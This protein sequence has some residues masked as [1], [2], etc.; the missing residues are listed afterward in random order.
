MSMLYNLHEYYSK[1]EI[2]VGFSS[3]NIAPTF[4]VVL[5]YGKQIPLM[6]FYNRNIY[7]KTMILEVGELE[8]ALIAC[9]VIG[10]RG[11][12]AE[13]IKSCI[14]DKLGIRKESIILA[15]THNHSYP[16]TSDP[17][18]REFIKDK[19]ILSVR[20][21]LNSKFKAKIG[22]GKKKLPVWINVNRTRPDGVVDTTL[23]VI[24]VDEDDAMRG[25]IF[26]FPS[27]PNTHTTAWGG[28][29]PGKIGPEW[30]EYV[31]KYIETYIDREQM[32]NLYPEIDFRD[33]FTMFLLGPA[34]D[35]Q[36]SLSLYR[37]KGKILSRKRVFV[38][39]LGDHIIDLANQIKTLPE[40]SLRFKWAN[41]KIPIRGE[42]IKKIR[43]AS[44]KGKSYYKKLEK[45][46]KSGL[47]ETIIQALIL[48]DSCICTA[49]GEVTADLGL[50]FQRRVKFSH[51]IL[52][53]IAN[54]YLGYFVSEMLG[55]ENIRYEAKGSLLCAERGRILVNSLLS[56]VNPKARLLERVRPDE[57]M[58]I[59][60]G[61]VEYDGDS[62]LYIGIKR[63]CNTPAYGE[64][65]AAPFLGRRIKIEKNGYFRFEKIAPGILYLYVDK[66]I[67]KEKK[68]KLLMWG[69][70]VIVKPKEITKI[71]IKVPREFQGKFVRNIK[72][73]KVEIDGYNVYCKINIEGKLM[74]NEKIKGWMFRLQDVYK[75]HKTFIYHPLTEALEENTGLFVFRNLFPDDYAIFFWIDVNMN[76]RM[77][78]GVDKISPHRILYREDFIYTK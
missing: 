57:D 13:Y 32:F 45:Y 26:I 12:D 65:P 48:N 37:Y 44:I 43:E 59:I 66:V 6:N 34:G 8:L 42:F 22:F 56:L 16:R 29:K 10:F 5:P 60:E 23:Y 47:Y 1:G 72:I 35:L 51:P 54:D 63:E 36:P 17:K 71:K 38:E 52:V 73:D 64:P 39:M 14:E 20:N 41:I 19:V 27:H 75:H 78:F 46:I 70:P 25:V 50:E 7:C 24:R 4:P 31:R 9:D 76:N 40:A 21:A 69:E 11:E 61:K 58:G 77:E 18:I 49:P 55:I 74:E 15:A 2:H 3:E 30:P 28:E 33:V 68:P 53:T 67:E 62:E